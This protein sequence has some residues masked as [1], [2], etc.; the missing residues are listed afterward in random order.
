MPAHVTTTPGSTT[1]PG[2][3]AE[4]DPAPRVLTT[5][6]ELAGLLASADPPVVLDVRWG[7]G[8]PHGRAHHR[9]GHI[10]GAVF[11]DLGTE[12]AAPAAPH[13]G[14]HPLPAVDVLQAAARRWG[15]SAGRPVVVY[16]DNGNTAAAR[17]WWL[18]RWAGVAEVTLLD[19]A[20][21]AWRGAGLPLETGEPAVE[22]GDITL[23]AGHLPTVDADE[24]AALAR[25]G[26]LLDARAAERYR[27]ETEPVDP[28][29]GHIPGA[30]SAPTGGNLAP[31]GTFLP[32]DALRARFAALGAGGAGRVAVY[33]GSGV[34]AA[35][36]IAAL[37]LAGTEAA[38][39]PGSWS[40]WSADPAR[41]AATGHQPG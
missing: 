9:A 24:A 4:H 8:D 38:L 27:G 39:F 34:T 3:P 35:H 17:A 10:P 18:L 41:P 37:A 32:P 23:G 15:V 16:D 13:D 6:A 19:G 40:A 30:R 25:S 11:A 31:D 21:G 28:R 14:R 22:P 26:T 29:A 2:V 5:V 12:L 20:L 7:L 1:P 36:Q 33:C